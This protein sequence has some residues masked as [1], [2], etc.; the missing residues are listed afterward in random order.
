MVE[1]CL[2]ILNALL[3]RYPQAR[4]TSVVQPL[5]AADFEAQAHKHLSRQAAGGSIGIIRMTDD[6]IVLVKRSGMHAG[7]ALPGGT[8]EHGEDFENAFAREIDEEIGVSLSDI[9]LVEIE[10]K[11]FVSPMGKTLDFVLAVFTAEATGSV[12]PVPTPDARAEGLTVALFQPDD[13]PAQMVLG[14]RQKAATYAHK[15]QDRFE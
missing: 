7:W 8:V 4:V 11:Q 1:P 13:L 6:R 14:D 5:S 10:S 3:H 2:D 15:S 12:L 9:Q